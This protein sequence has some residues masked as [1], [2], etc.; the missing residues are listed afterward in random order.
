MRAGYIFAALLGGAALLWGDSVGSS[1]L[2]LQ[3]RPEATLQA[4]GERTVRVKIRLARGTTA[5]LAAQDACT[6]APAEARVL[7]QSG[8]YQVTLPG[9]GKLACLYTAGGVLTAALP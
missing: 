4:A 5:R 3:I 1:T 2:V 6:E 7:E 8:T 9:Q